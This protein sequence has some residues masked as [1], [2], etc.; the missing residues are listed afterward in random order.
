MKPA[1]RVPHT[2]PV[3]LPTPC[4]PLSLAPTRRVDGG[5]V[6]QAEVPLQVRVLQ[7]EDM[8]GCWVRGLGVSGWERAQICVVRC[9]CSSA[10]HACTLARPGQ[11]PE[12]CPTPPASSGCTAGL[13]GLVS[14]PI[15]LVHGPVRAIRGPKCSG[16]TALGAPG[17]LTRKGATKAPEAPSTWM[18]TFH[19][20]F[21]FS[22]AGKHGWQDQRPT[23]DA[24]PPHNMQGAHIARDMKTKA[25]QLCHGRRLCAA[26]WAGEATRAPTRAQRVH[27]LHILKLPVVG[28]AKHGGDA[29][30]QGREEGGRWPIRGTQRLPLA[31]GWAGRHLAAGAQETPCHGAHFR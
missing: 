1:W 25:G 23:R 24:P 12:G 15:R 16:G 26:R 5:H 10:G 22:S 9:M 29:C 6:T 21:S 31:A 4:L 18:D 2:L 11:P 27:R 14:T 28:G 17:Q 13:S 3:G 8:G 20:F 30:G 19:P 7:G